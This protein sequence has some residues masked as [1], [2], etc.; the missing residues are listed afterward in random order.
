MKKRLDQS[1]VERGLAPSRTRARE[2]IDAGQV[3]VGGTLAAKASQEIAPQDLI[4]VLPGDVDRFVSRGGLKLDSALERTGI[5]PEN[6][7]VLDVGQSTGGFTDCLLQRQARLVVGLDVGRGQLHPRLAGD[8]RVIC[9]EGINARDP[10]Q[11]AGLSSHFGERGPHLIVS[12]L[13]FISLTVVLPALARLATPGTPLLSLVK[14]QFEV[15]P[16]GLG[17]GGIVRDPLL[18][19]EVERKIRAAAEAAG[20]RVVSYFESALEG[21][22]GNKEFFLHAVKN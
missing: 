15:G 1:L 19:P 8:A 5:N 7:A 22:D 11:L 10:E 13:S 4:Q 16:Q 20:F 2:M 18:Y 6:W 14:P 12:D 17:R 9:I 21:K 3:K